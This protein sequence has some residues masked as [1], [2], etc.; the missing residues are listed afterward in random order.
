MKIGMTALIVVQ[1]NVLETVSVGLQDLFC[2]V[3]RDYQIGVPDIEMKAE[4]GHGVQ[5]FAQLSCG[6]IVTGKVLDHQA[7]PAALSFG[8][9]LL[10]APQV[11]F[12]VKA[13]GVPRRV[14]VRMDVHPLGTCF[15]ELLNAALQFSDCG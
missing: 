5:K 2:R 6:V 4:F 7:N 11:L 8:Q 15:G 13:S 12:D 14:T 9:E 3:L 1:M 10:E